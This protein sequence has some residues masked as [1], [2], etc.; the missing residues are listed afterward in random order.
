VL[1]AVQEI[2]KD[3]RPD[4]VLSGINHGPNMGEDVIYSGTVA[5]AMEGAMLGIPSFAF[6]LAAWHPKD[7][8]GAAHFV[9]N[10]LPEILANPLH[11][12]TLLN[13]NIPE[14]PPQQIKGYRMVR[15]GSRVYHDVIT[16]HTDPRGRPYLWIGGHGPT[17]TADPDTDFCAVQ[18][19]Y[20]SVTPLI[21]DL[22]HHELLAEMSAQLGAHAPLARQDHQG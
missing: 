1:V 6:S 21:I 12:R 2:L 9:R 22:T 16:T 5:A 19:G 4:L 11:K 17:W 14:L 18:S 3:D 7:F 8:S 13:I 15:L 10:W 20:I